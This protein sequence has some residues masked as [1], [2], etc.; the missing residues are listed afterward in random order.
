MRWWAAFAIVAV[1]L[2]AGWFEPLTQGRDDSWAILACVAAAALGLGLGV[3][4]WPALAGPVALVAGVVAVSGFE[5]LS[6]WFALFLGLPAL[7]ALVAIGAGLARRRP[8]RAPRA[9][10]A[11]F[12]VA[13]VPLLWAVAT[14]VQR[15]LADEL[16]A[17]VQAQ[18]PIDKSLGNLCPGASTPR[19]IAEDLRQR[20]EVLLRELREHP[21]RL[22]T[23]TY[24]W[25]DDDPEQERI[26]VRELAQEQLRDLENGGGSCAPD[27]QRRLREAL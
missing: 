24:H 19:D 9:A 18:L 1:A 20:S 22:V 26:T 15:G 23:Y 21:G 11:A 17:A 16:P 7:C 6:T 14:T 25:A 27:L 12:A 4:R 8:D 10:A 3:G 5:T 13:A 2:L